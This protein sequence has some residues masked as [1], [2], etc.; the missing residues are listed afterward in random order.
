[1]RL[2]ATITSKRLLVAVALVLIVGVAISATRARNALT[3]DIDRLIR[4]GTADG[5]KPLPDEVLANL[6]LPVA[7]YLR[8]A[9]P[10]PNEIQEV[11]LTQTGTLRTD[12]MAERWMAFEAEHVAV[13]GA[14]GFVWNARVE[15]APLVHVRVHDA[16]IDRTGF[17]RVSLLSIV[18]LSAASGGIEMD[19]GSLHRYLAEAVWYPTALRPSSRLQWSPIDEKSALATLTNDRTSVSLEF[20]FADNGEVTGIYTPARWG[21]FPDGYRQ[22]PWEGHFRDYREHQGIRVPSHGEV[23]W[24]INNEWRPVWKGTV[25]AYQ[26]RFRG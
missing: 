24:Y 9:L 14:M 22:V 5:S 4:S 18:P 12:A 11:R 1:V 3:A 13:P 15:A 8:L 2:E 26:V 20:R 16:L 25:V 7:R 23:G 17:G 21:T 6:P 10:V 19:S